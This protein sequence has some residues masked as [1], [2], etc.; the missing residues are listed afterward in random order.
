[1]LTKEALEFIRGLAVAASN[2]AVHGFEEP[3]EIPYAFL[4][5]GVSAESLEHL[6]PAPSRFRGEFT[7]RRISD[8]CSYIADNHGKRDA[9][10]PPASGDTRVFIDPDEI[11]ATAIFGLGTQDA[12]GWGAHSAVLEPK[13]T[14]PYAALKHGANTNEN[15]RSFSQLDFVD[16]IGDW[17]KHLQFYDESEAPIDIALA[18]KLVRTLTAKAENK[19]EQSVG[20]HSEHRSEMERIEVQSREGQSLPAG[21]HFTCNPYDELPERTFNCVLRSV[22]DTSN[23]VK[24]LYRIVGLEAAKLEIANE[25]L[26]KVRG[27]LVGKELS[28]LGESAR[29]G[30][31]KKGAF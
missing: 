13:E 1:M 28:T 15:R 29:I 12:P 19:A 17:L 14:A 31:F 26:A 27:D 9:A 23:R 18:T 6:Q 20:H 24:L 8:F 11:K 16:F 30:K 7:T 25:F 21:F 4:P 2:P 10:H 5:Q 22:V 3:G